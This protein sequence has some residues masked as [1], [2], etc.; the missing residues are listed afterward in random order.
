MME[1]KVLTVISV[2]LF[3]VLTVGLSFADDEYDPEE[4]LSTADEEL[5]VRLGIDQDFSE[6]QG[7]VN[8]ILVNDT[9]HQYYV[10]DG[11]GTDILMTLFPAPE[12]VM[13]GNK[14]LTFYDLWDADYHVSL[15]MNRTESIPDASAGNCWLRITDYRMRGR[16][17][18]HELIILPGEK[19]YKKFGESE[20]VL[21][22]LDSL[23]PETPIK[24][25]LIRLA[26]T[27]YVYADENFLFSCEDD[28]PYGIS[29]EA[30]AVLYGMG[31]RVRCDFDDISI[32]FLP[33]EL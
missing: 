1:K 22:E 8:E 15:T 25:D 20:T 16:G 7:Y 27:M 24:F 33:A 19:V 6:D 13:G 5:F 4:L 11:V 12:R 2:F 29:F 32:R 21:F 3:F 28:I 17:N 26:G 30:G 31:N 14:R 18:E 10:Y 23:S 9:I